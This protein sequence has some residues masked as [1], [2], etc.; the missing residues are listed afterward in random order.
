[1]SVPAADFSSGADAEE[2]MVVEPGPGPDFE[3]APASEENTLK[4]M[5]EAL[6][7]A[8]AERQRPLPTS[9]DQQP[10]RSPQTAAMMRRKETIDRLELWLK[11]VMKEK[12][13]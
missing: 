3:T 10:A 9:A 2:S 7:E 6:E 13:Q 8:E 5:Q 12:P 4:A 11:N 1:M